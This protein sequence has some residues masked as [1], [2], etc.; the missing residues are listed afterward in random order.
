MKVRSGASFGSAPQPQGEAAICPTVVFPRE[1]LPQKWMTKE[2]PASANVNQQGAN[3]A[4]SAKSI[5]GCRHTGAA[6]CVCQSVKVPRAC[7]LRTVGE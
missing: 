4:Q 6:T 3:P 7:T 5:G 2:S 1:V